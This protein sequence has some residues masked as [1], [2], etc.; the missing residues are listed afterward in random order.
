VT[1]VT[2]FGL[3]GHS[4]EVARGSGATIVIQADAV[5]LLNQAEALVQAGFVTG[6]SGRN[7]ASYGEGIDLPGDFPDWRRQLLAD[8][9]TSGGL[10]VAV[11]PE[12]ANAL[13]ATIREAGYPRAAIIGSVEAGPPRV[14][15]TA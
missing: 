11:A 1:D 12:R 4:L 13:L 10:L 5:P 9:Q 6:A 7:W 15:V 3:L 2:G 14:R 8:P